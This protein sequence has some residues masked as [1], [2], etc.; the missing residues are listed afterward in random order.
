MNNPYFIRAMLFGCADGPGQVILQWPDNI[1]GED[2]ED[3]AECINM[4]I[5]TI[6]RIIGE[7]ERAAKESATIPA[8]GEV[9]A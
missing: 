9:D 6:R 4:Q 2:L 7:R 1:S 3:A 8:E 5:N